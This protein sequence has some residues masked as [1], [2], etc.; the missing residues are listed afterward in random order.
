MQTDQHCC[1]Q[2]C[3]VSRD[4][5]IVFCDLQWPVDCSQFNC[6]ILELGKKSNQI[7][8]FLY[9]LFLFRPF[10]IEQK[11]RVG[12]REPILRLYMKNLPVILSPCQYLLSF[13]SYAAQQCKGYSLSLED[14]ECFKKFSPQQ[15]LKHIKKNP[16]KSSEPIKEILLRFYFIITSFLSLAQNVNIQE[17]ISQLK[18]YK[19]VSCIYC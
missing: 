9:D 6:H 3:K 18:F 13:N 12:G 8:L 14:T 16:S 2:H 5:K 7:L 15:I 1:H 17:I 4:Q 10:I 19:K 11:W